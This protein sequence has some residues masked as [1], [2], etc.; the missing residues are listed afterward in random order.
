[1]TD[2]RTEDRRLVDATLAGDTESFR[3]LVER[4]SGFV[5]GVCGRILGD[6]TE[7]QDVAQETFLRSY[8]ALAT[9]RGDGTFRSWVT[10]IA[11]RQS[12]A[13]LATRREALHLDL[14]DG[15]EGLAATL[16]SEDDLEQASL[17]LELRRSIQQAVAALPPHQRDVVAMRFF[18]DLSLDEI[19]EATSSPIGT[20]K[21]RLH[22]GLATLRD[23][24]ISRQAE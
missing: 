5:I 22:R 2:P 21:S 15:S 13:R 14:E 11:V 6:A 10:R 12:V 19:A 24:L 8:Q 23:R 18:G 17:D 20:V 9:F 16:T 1:V 7:A 4:E 3:V